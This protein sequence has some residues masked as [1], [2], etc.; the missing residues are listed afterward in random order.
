M[1]NYN[2]ISHALR[3]ILVMNNNP[4]YYNKKPSLAKEGF[5]KIIIIALNLSSNEDPPHQSLR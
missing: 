5:S 2:E 4:N 1:H 3:A